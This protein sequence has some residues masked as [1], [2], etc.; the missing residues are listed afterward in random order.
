MGGG[1]YGT[2][3]SPGSTFSNDVW[4]SADG[5]TWRCDCEDAPWA[6]RRYH[7]V[8]VYD[9]RLWVIAGCNFG[10]ADRAAQRGPIEDPRPISGGAWHA[11]AAQSVGLGTNPRTGKPDL[12]RCDVWWSEDGAEWHEIPAP[13]VPRHAACLFV[14]A[15]EMVMTSGSNGDD[16]T[17]FPMFPDVWALGRA[18]AKL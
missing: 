18:V 14:T 8:A 1:I 4:S 15:D 3:G 6:P 17:E 10:G 5:I 7:S 12:N 2:P 13:W 9:D 16:S 11:T